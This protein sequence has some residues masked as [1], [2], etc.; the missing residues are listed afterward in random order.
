MQA[1]LDDKTNKGG[2]K[3]QTEDVKDFSWG[4]VEWTK[5]LRL[6]ES[7]QSLVQVDLA[8]ASS[9]TCDL[10]DKWVA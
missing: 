6:W 4:G 8:D 1:G 9:K 5:A 3:L 10:A 7:F 2:E